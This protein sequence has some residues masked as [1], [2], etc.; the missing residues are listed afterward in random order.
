MDEQNFH[1]AFRR[2]TWDDQLDEEN[3]STDVSKADD[4]TLK[5]PQNSIQNDGKSS[6]LTTPAL[7]DPRLRSA[8]KPVPPPPPKISSSR[9]RSL[10][11]EPREPS[12]V[13]HFYTPPAEPIHV[14]S[15]QTVAAE[16]QALY[17]FTPTPVPSNLI[18]PLSHYLP[19][20][21]VAINPFPHYL[22]PQP[23]P[24]PGPSFVPRTT[25][26][27]TPTQFNSS[28]PRQAQPIGILVSG[29][30]RPPRGPTANF[31]RHAVPP[32]PYPGVNPCTNGVP[33]HFVPPPP[34]I[35]PMYPPPPP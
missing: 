31:P 21:P 20:P 2:P 19:P 15:S 13:L 17:Q 12:P 16:G 4:S 3:K 8:G 10:S 1:Q 32:A 28:N 23:L 29:A 11:P 35:S 7:S 5:A 26:L 33:F 6:T 25:L 24:Q 34:F 22:P 27:S 9:L 30:R 18:N 14:P